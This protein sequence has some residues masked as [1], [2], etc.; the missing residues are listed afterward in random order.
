MFTHT[1]VLPNEIVKSFSALPK[2]ALIVDGTLGKGGHSKLLLEHEFKIIGID[3][4]EEALEEAKKQLA[5]ENIEFVHGNF[6][7]IKKIL[8]GRKAYGILL[9][10]GVS[11]HQLEKEGRGFGF[12]GKLD[13]RMNQKDELTAEKIVNEYAHEKL[14][15]L[16]QEYGEK[17]YT[18]EITEKIC[19]ARKNGR[20]ETGEQLVKIIETALP[21]QYR[22]TRK[23]HWATP[24]FRAL[25]IAVNDDFGHLKKFLNTFTDCLNKGGVL[26]IIT[27]HT[28]EERVVKQKL[29]ELKERKV[30]KL[31][32]KK[33]ATATKQE[34]SS[35]KKSARAKLWTA[36]MR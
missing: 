27:F 8:A 30:M 25:R 12:K 21:E 33:P 9:D 10:L 24:T 11:T 32:T 36:E 16:L 23:H 6:S 17:V 15:E 19:E 7:D 4:D 2:G 1:P 35:N 31:I 28:M 34:I 18:K 26:S 5:G 22:K 29:R 13:M 3:R 20:I 14:A